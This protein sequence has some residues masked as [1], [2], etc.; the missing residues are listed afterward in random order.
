MISKLKNWIEKER[1]IREAK[2]KRI[3]PKNGGKFKNSCFLLIEE[4]FDKLA[5]RV[6]KIF[7]RKMR[8]KWDASLQ[9][10]HKHFNGISSQKPIEYITFPEL[11]R[12]LEKGDDERFW[13][14]IV[15]NFRRC[16]ELER[17]LFSDSFLIKERRGLKIYFPPYLSLLY[18]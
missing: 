16:R 3:S 10:A 17:E 6:N 7:F 9:F 18:W 1:F 14:I 4:N 11:T 13:E 15:K 12:I 5:V 2:G 8:T